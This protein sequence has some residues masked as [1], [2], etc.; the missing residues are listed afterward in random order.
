MALNGSSDSTDNELF[1]TTEDI[2]CIKY[3]RV[4]E[5]DVREVVRTL[6]DWLRQQ[7]HLPEFADTRL[8]WGFWLLRKMSLERTKQTVDMYY[9]VRN[10]I[11]EFFKNR[12]PVIL[13]EQQIF[14]NL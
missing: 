12:D 9:T 11:P 3:S 4:S 6:Q 7:P 13:Q 1:L 10:L 2:E 5:N 14:K 8:L